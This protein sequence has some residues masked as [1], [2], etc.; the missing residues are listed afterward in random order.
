M[1]RGY[2]DIKTLAREMRTKVSDLLVLSPQND[3][4][5][6]GLPSREEAGRWF[7]DVWEKFGFSDGVHL[8][9]IH[10]RLV[11][12]PNTKPDGSRYLNSENDWQFLGVAS[13][14]AR[15][16]KLVPAEAFVD[17][18][19]PHPAL[20]ARKSAELRTRTTLLNY[21]CECGDGLPDTV[22][23]PALY[24]SDFEGVQEYL[25]EIWVEK[26]TVDD[27]LDPLARRLKINL[28][29]GVGEMSE[30]AARNAVGRAVDYRKP[31]RILY[32][33]D[34]DPKGRQMPVSLSRKIQFLLDD[35]GLDLDIELQPIVLTPEQCATYDLPRSFIEKRGN[36]HADAFEEKH[37]EGATEL[38]ALE[39]L[40]PGELAKIVEREVCR[41]IDPDLHN[42]VALA[43]RDVLS[44][45]DEI[46]DD[47]QER[48]RVEIDNFN[49]QFQRIKNDLDSL[50]EDGAELWEGI[51]AT[52]E[53]DAPVITS[54]DVPRPR[55]PEPIAEPLFRS[56]RSYL[57]QLDH[58][59]A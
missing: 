48:Y 52:L 38:D 41:Y 16:L 21:S 12:T 25:V 26:S 8:R 7:A 44:R 29:T 55:D 17:R 19:N 20:Y 46:D 39:S 32:V 11:V 47:V 4:Y 14:A 50:R 57:Y 9:R 40:R 24:V 59:R 6:A 49:A 5:Y 2:Q 13:L 27:V 18:R 34:F 30:T 58:Y 3:P 54:D 33:S 53:A 10:Y 15:Y 45:L 35:A 37:G 43:K 31:L 56:K 36:G 51:A 42:R 1:I 22:G 23:L 28:V